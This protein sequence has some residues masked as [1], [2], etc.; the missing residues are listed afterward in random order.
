MTSDSETTLKAG[1]AFGFEA[2]LSDAVRKPVQPEVTIL[3]SANVSNILMFVAFIVI[4]VSHNG[5]REQTA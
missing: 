3:I 2:M 1:S 4:R 5:E